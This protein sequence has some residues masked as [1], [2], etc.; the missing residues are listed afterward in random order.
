MESKLNFQIFSDL[1]FIINFFRVDCN[2]LGSVGWLETSDTTVWQIILYPNTNICKFYMKEELWC[3]W[4]TSVTFKLTSVNVWE[5]WCHWLTSLTLKLTSVKVWELGKHYCHRLTNDA[6]ISILT[7]VDLWELYRYHYHSLIS[8]PGILW[9][10]TLLSSFEILKSWQ[11]SENL[12]HHLVK[13]PLK[14]NN[15]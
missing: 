15:S 5:L 14:G 9:Q 10:G 8:N 1:F 6:V 13:V 12:S 3:Y 2:I 7:S 4:L 11:I